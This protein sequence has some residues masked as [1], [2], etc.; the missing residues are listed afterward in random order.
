MAAKD[1]YQK[2]YYVDLWLTEKCVIE[3]NLSLNWIEIYL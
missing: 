3:K 1:E 2:V